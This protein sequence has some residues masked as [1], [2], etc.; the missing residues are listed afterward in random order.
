VPDDPVA[1]AARRTL[2]AGTARLWLATFAVQVK[3][4]KP[5]GGA[6]ARFQRAFEETML[7]E[8]GVV[9]LA[10]RRAHVRM[11]FPWLEALAEG[12]E[13]R[14]PWL[15]DDDADEAQ[16]LDHDPWIEVLQAGAMGRHPQN[17]RPWILDGLTAARGSALLGNE[18][19]RES[20]T[21]RY[22]F[23][24]VLNDAD[25]ANLGRRFSR[26][27]TGNAWVDDDGLIRRVVWTTAHPLRSRL[28]RG[29][30]DSWNVLELWDFGVSAD[31]PCE[32]P[33]EDGPSP[34]R[35]SLISGLRVLAGQRRAWKRAHPS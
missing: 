19:I 24:A 34:E 11:R 20:P 2:G 29:K 4:R 22:G 23:R 35:A 8:V 7:E 31:V 33:R 26:V 25:V 9:D 3:P 17:Y 30:A 6:W 27:A 18:V 10:G 15:I 32:L 16:G 14:W 13:N 5:P 1:T 28:P 12:V 21:A